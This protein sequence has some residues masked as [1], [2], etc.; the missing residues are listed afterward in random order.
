[1][2]ESQFDNA[3]ETI[4]KAIKLDKEY[5]WAWGVKGNI[6]EDDQ[7]WDKAITALDRATQLSPMYQW[8]WTVKA[9]S[10]RQIGAYEQALREVE[11]S[12]G[13]SE[14]YAMAWKVKANSFENLLQREEAL[15]ALEWAVAIESEDAGSWAFRAEVLRRM[16]RYEEALAA[17]TR[18]LKIA[19]QYVWGWRVRSEILDSMGRYDEAF[20]YLAENIVSKD[21]DV[22]R[23][24]I[25]SLR[26]IGNADAVDLLIK[27]LNDIDSDVQ[28]A[29]AW[30]LGILGDRRAT[31]SLIEKLRDQSKNVQEAAIN[32]LLNINDP[33]T[34]DALMA[35]LDEAEDINIR[36]KLVRTILMITDK[37][38]QDELVKDTF[39]AE[40]ENVESFCSGLAFVKVDQESALVRMRRMSQEYP[41]NPMIQSRM[42]VLL[43]RMG[44]IDESITFHNKAVG[45]NEPTQIFYS[46]RGIAY[47]TKENYELASN[48]YR[49]AIRL[50]P[51]WDSLW[52]ALGSALFEMGDL[53]SALQSWWRAKF[54]TC[55]DS[56]VL[57]A[58]S[59]GLY[60]L[61]ESQEAQRLWLKA[62]SREPKLV[63]NL[64]QIK[65][66]QGWGPRMIEKV[67]QLNERWH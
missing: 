63:N 56:Y 64:E 49:Q 1:M 27:S 54:A 34:S 43:R 19:N 59:I 26:E 48:D 45:S 5:T 31:S 11:T 29:S 30:A 6:L 37:Y 51:S 3:L 35:A 7:K 57:A 17:I 21:P 40:E 47:S 67:R 23:C 39:L 8:G 4:E 18:S 14:T 16:K 22:R 55:G 61:G 44:Y 46:S 32:S 25:W 52:E 28:I 2:G 12:I 24:V 41:Q 65:L 58:L 50:D 66:D 33:T 15:K 20:A 9:E 38:L 53:S 60:E 36:R 10:H 13:V 42:G 62:I